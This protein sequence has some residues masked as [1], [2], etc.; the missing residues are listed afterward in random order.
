MTCGWIYAATWSQQGLCSGLFGL[1]GYLSDG[2]SGRPASRLDVGAQRAP[3]L[4]VNATFGDWGWYYEQ[5][6]KYQPVGILN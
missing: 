4:L 5:G 1:F 3:R 2:P 6:S